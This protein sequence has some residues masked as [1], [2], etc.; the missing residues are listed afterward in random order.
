MVSGWEGFK[1]HDHKADGQLTKLT[2]YTAAVNKYYYGSCRV[3]TFT[4][5]VLNFLP[6]SSKQILFMKPS[7]PSI[8]LRSCELIVHL[9]LTAQLRILCSYILSFPT[10]N[11]NSLSQLS[12]CLWRCCF[13]KVSCPQNTVQWLQ[14][15]QWSKSNEMYGAIHPFFYKNIYFI[16]ISR[17]KF[18]KF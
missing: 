1:T 5:L 2:K 8:S 18:A 12:V 13:F 9:S 3:H 7:C 4:P 17:L 16:R 14:S 10:W 6:S 11:I 15:N